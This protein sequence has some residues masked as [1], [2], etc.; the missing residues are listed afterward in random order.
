MPMDRLQTKWPDA[1]NAAAIVPTQEA[2]GTATTSATLATKL[3]ATLASTTLAAT[4]DAV[5]ANPSL[6]PTAAGIARNLAAA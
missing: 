6:E 5:A 3:A 4:K 1:A 2:R